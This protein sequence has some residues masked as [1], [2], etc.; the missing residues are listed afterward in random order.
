M[1]DTPIN[2][3]ESLY[4]LLVAAHSHPI[5]HRHL[6]GLQKYHEPHKTL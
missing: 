6:S 1:S 5:L 2:T 3:V 4:L